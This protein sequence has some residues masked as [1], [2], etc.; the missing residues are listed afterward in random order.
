MTKKVDILIYVSCMVYD[1]E[2]NE[3]RNNE[4]VGFRETNTDKVVRE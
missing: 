2:Y 4:A 1:K 3:S